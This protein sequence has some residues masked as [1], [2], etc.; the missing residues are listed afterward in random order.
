MTEHRVIGERSRLIFGSPPTCSVC[1]FII[2]PSVTT[3][4]VV[5]AYGLVLIRDSERNLQTS[6]RVGRFVPSTTCAMRET[7]LVET[8]PSTESGVIHYRP[9]GGR[10]CLSWTPKIG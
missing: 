4:A 2:H 7:S 5:F 6:I 1:N 10:G 8:A 3:F 9:S